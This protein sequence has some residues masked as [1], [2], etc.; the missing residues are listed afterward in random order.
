MIIAVKIVLTLLVVF[1]AIVLIIWI[2]RWRAEDVNDLRQ[3]Y[4]TLTDALSTVWCYEIVIV[5]LILIIAVFAIAILA[6]WTA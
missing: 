2:P 1:P 3:W 4:L 5:V 6:I